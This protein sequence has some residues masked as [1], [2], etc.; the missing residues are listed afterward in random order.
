MGTTLLKTMKKKLLILFSGLLGFMLLGFAAIYI[1]IDIDVRKNIRT[2]REL[3]PGIAEDAL[4]AF[5]VD[6]TNSPRDRSSVA[7]WTLGQIHSEKAIPILEDLYMN[8]PEGRTCHR[9][10]DSV[11]CQY[12]IYKALRA[13]K[14][15]WWPLHRRLNR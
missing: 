12:E 9:N 3:Y 4:I 13:C 5:L 15:N 7:V 14:S 6:T 1:W 8:D 11:L 10:H 2:A